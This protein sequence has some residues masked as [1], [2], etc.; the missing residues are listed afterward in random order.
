MTT[1]KTSATPSAKDRAAD[2]RLQ[3]TFGI[4]LAE[5]NLILKYQKDQCAICHSPPNGRRL[6]VDHD[7]ITGAL[8]GLLCMLCNRALG[9][10]RDNDLNV[11]NAA[12]YVK[13][14]PVSAVFGTTR[15]TA[16]GR[17]GSKKRAKALKLLVQAVKS[18]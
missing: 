18:N 11:A 13:M 14:P 6:A 9:R 15:F 2:L 4:T 1:K 5:Y 17:V 8:R 12:V 3:R 10:W 7:H 16:P